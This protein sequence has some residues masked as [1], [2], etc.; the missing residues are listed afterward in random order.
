MISTKKFLDFLAETQP[1]S[2]PPRL[3]LLNFIKNNFDEEDPIT[4]DVFDRFID[5]CLDFHH[6]MGHRVQL[7]NEIQYLIEQF[8]QIYHEPLDTSNFRWPQDL[9]IIEVCH[10]KD[11]EDLAWVFADKV[12]DKSEIVKV[13]LDGSKRALI[14]RHLPNHAMIVHIIDRKFV[15]RDGVLEPLKKDHILAY[16]PTMDLTSKIIHK[17]EMG[18]QMVAEFR[19]E[20][21]K[22]KGKV[23]RGYLFQKHLTWDGTPLTQAFQLFSYL[24]KTEQLFIGRDKDSYY[25]ELKH[26]LELTLENFQEGDIQLHTWSQFLLEQVDLAIKNIY[27]QD[28]QLRSLA[29][30][31]SHNL[32]K[33]PS[34]KH[35]ESRPFNQPPP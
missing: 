6:W 31:L 25:G 27:V 16:D 7:S 20:Q 4:M 34:L 11:L 18:P 1:A 26:Q 2:S 23:I 15:L 19:L 10:Q 13:V 22:L 14:L 30:D 12:S 24:K 28:A 21:G 33:K 8:N 17:V 29:E 32:K 3:A 9:Q 35:E 5:A